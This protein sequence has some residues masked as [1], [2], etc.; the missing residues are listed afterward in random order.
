MNSAKELLSKSGESKRKLTSEG[1][2]GVTFKL[3]QIY[4]SRAQ[5]GDD[6]VFC[7]LYKPGKAFL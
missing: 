2:L 6:A 3:A 1:L 7:E 5:I 4:K